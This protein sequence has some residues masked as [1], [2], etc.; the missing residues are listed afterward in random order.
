VASGGAEE[1]HLDAEG[2]EG[3]H[4]AAEA[5]GETFGGG[6]PG[7]CAGGA[8]DSEGAEEGEELGGRAGPEGV[9]LH[10]EA[11]GLG[12]G[13]GDSGFGGRGEGGE[14]GVFGDA[15][16]WGGGEGPGGGVGQAGGGVERDGFAAAE[17]GAA[18]RAQGGAAV[19]VGW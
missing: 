2:A 16:G 3:R 15:E 8:L 4:R 6:G 1:S 11:D 17:S 13:V 14:H 18:G 5:L 10:E 9:I 7:E 12:D 19:G